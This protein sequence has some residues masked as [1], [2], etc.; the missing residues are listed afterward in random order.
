MLYI[1]VYTNFKLLLRINAFLLS[2]ILNIELQLFNYIRI[3]H[4]KVAYI[5]LNIWTLMKG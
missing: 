3:I 4:F 2:A 1:K 5:Y